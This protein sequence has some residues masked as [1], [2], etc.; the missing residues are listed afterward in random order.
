M[1]GWGMFLFGLI[2]GLI[3]SAVILILARGSPGRPVERLPPLDPPGIQVLVGGAVRATGVF[4]PPAG[5]LVEQALRAAGGLLPQADLEDLNLA[6]PL[7]AGDEVRVRF[8]PTAVPTPMPGALPAATAP[9]PDHRVNVNTASLAELDTLPGIGLTLAQR[10][11][12]ER[13]RHGPFTRVEDLPRVSGIGPT[14]L[15]K[16]RD[17][18]S[19]E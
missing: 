15:E 6:A 4:N 12:D 5:I 16:I 3:A 2:T 14:L 9:A 17:L 18:V 7:I 10:I 8:R 1:A 13:E 19:V 11:I